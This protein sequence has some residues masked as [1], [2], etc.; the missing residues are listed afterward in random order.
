V[1]T[2]PECAAEHL[3]GTLFC[4]RCGAAV[5]P[6]AQAHVARVAPARRGPF[7]ESAPAAAESAPAR[8]RPE[9]LAPPDAGARPPALSATI[10]HRRHAL[11]LHGALIHIG[12]SDPDVG[13]SP[14]L[15][16]TPFDGLERGVSRR[17]AAI[18]WAAGGFVII[19]QH[20][21]NGTWLDG[22]R[23]VPGY[24]YQLPPRATVRFGDLV[25]QLAVEGS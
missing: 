3:P 25:V 22:V 5:H 11:T 20:S 14:E 8:R 9:A 24:A 21:N 19:D 13:F 23:L 7:V 6:A 2:C 10:A 1:I 4:D 15:D 12:R 16:L 18:Q 17:H